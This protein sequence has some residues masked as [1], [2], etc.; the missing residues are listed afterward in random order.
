VQSGRLWCPGDS[1]GEVPLPLCGSGNG[2]TP[3]GGF[4]F[5]ML[6]DLQTEGM[7]EPPDGLS[8]W[9]ATST[10]LQV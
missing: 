3:P 10:P 1:L 2:R 7:A 9:K 6:G 8:L 4:Q 5:D